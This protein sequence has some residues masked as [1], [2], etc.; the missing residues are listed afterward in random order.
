MREFNPEKQSLDSPVN[1]LVISAQKDQDFYEL[2]KDCKLSNGRKVVVEVAGWQDITLTSYHDSKSICTL[3]ASRFPIP[4]S[5][6][7]RTRQFIPDYLL[8]RNLCYTSLVSFI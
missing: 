4:N 8:V 3:R 2:F 6:Q 5:P 1:L 7:T